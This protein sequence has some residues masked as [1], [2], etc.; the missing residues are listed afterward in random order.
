MANLKFS[1]GYISGHHVFAGSMYCGDIIRVV[2]AI[3]FI[4]PTGNVLRNR[5]AVAKV[6]Q[7]KR[8][9]LE[10]MTVDRIVPNT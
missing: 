3:I 1:G 10:P 9:H 7:Y 6:Q 4:Q 5:D 8:L 2:V